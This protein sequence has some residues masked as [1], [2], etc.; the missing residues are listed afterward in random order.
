MIIINVF[1]ELQ[2]VLACCNPI[3]PLV[4][5][6]QHDI[7]VI[8]KKAKEKPLKVG[9]LNRSTK[10]LPKGFLLALYHAP[11]MSTGVFA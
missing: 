2:G 1:K 5:Q 4:R 11:D 7:H 3:P 10:R 8:V 9:K 6:Y